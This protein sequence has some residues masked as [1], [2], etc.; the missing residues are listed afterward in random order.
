MKK[1]TR[2]TLSTVFVIMILGGAI[3]GSCSGKVVE[4]EVVVAENAI[5]DLEYPPPYASVESYTVKANDTLSSIAVKYIPSDKYMQYWIEDVMRLND[6][7]KPIV[8]W[9]ETIEVL[10]Y[11]EGSVE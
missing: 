6:R 8:Y 3:L 11:E 9:G 2:K 7:T 5:A 10:T 4:E 1:K